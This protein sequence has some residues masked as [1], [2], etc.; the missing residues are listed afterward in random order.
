[1]ETFYW[2]IQYMFVLIS[3]FFVMFVWPS[4]VFRKHLKT[5]TRTYKFAFCI[6]VMIVLINSVCI[7]LGLFNILYQWLFC[8]LFYGT[9]LYSIF[10]GKRISPDTIKRFKY[11]ISGTYGS[12]SMFSDIF[13]FI[14]KKIKGVWK[15]FLKFMEGH[16]FEYVALFVVTIFAYTY[17]SYG[18]LHDYSF[19][20]GDIYVHCM[21]IYNLTSGAIFYSGIY[22]EG[23]HFFIYSE[24]TT[25]GV[26]M[27]S[28]IL[29]TQCI[30]MFSMIICLYIFFREIFKWK[31]SPLVALML[32]FTI[33]AITG[34]Q[35]FTIA[36]MQWI[37]PM[38][39]GYPVTL[40]CCTYL[41]KYLRFSIVEKK[42]KATKKAERKEI[43]LP[44][45]KKTLKIRIPLCFKDENLFIFTMAF[46]GTICIHFYDTIMAF[47][48]CIGIAIALVFKI[49][50]R[51][52]VP[53]IVAVTTG[54][55]IAAA[56]LVVCFA[57]GIPLQGSLYWAMNYFMP[58]DEEAVE[59]TDTVTTDEQGNEQSNEQSSTEAINTTT[60]NTEYSIGGP[61]AAKTVSGIQMLAATGKSL[62]EHVQSFFEMLRDTGY[63]ES[64]HG[65]ERGDFYF[66]FMLISL[67]IGCVATIIRIFYAKLKRIS[68]GHNS[69]FGYILIAVIGIAVHLFVCSK[70]M[71]LPF[72][73]EQYRICALA[74]MVAV[75]TIIVPIDL[76]LGIV[77]K[78]LPKF[79]K[80]LLTIGLIIAVYVVIRV[81]GNY[82][83]TLLYQLTR[84]NST[85]MVT[86]QI[87]NTL[88][89]NSYTIV[90][91]TDE[92]YQIL[93]YGYH[94]ELVH[95]INESEVVSYTLPSEY[96]FI[97]VEKNAL[98]RNQDHFFECP[99]WFSIDDKYY[100]KYSQKHSQ[101]DDLRKETIKEEYAD[102]YF[103]TFREKISAYGTLWQRVILNSKVYVWCQK[104]NAMY[105]NEM[106]VYYED[107]DLLVYYLKQN[108][109]N[110]YEL[111]A[112]DPSV[113][114]PPES[115]AD[116]IW[117]E[118]YKEKMAK[119]KKSTE[120]EK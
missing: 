46:A 75:P 84:Y 17:F 1:M 42:D 90:S 7:L 89:E 40:L 62:I 110:L 79:V 97:F 50:S 15:R 36:R 93:G 41:I 72:L 102:L 101:G 69:Y 82:R 49:F 117:P 67:S 53:L 71:G 70:K 52:L 86:K 111:A 29:F 66:F 27:Y 103:G 118:N 19:G 105:P 12:K 6:V 24:M 108:Q 112:M 31:Y 104:F 57:S 92:L 26:S 61:V 87:V 60:L 5:K 63:K 64:G 98:Y 45:I 59:T 68:L 114:V 119:T 95:F 48:V 16:W 80:S 10:K 33:D 43:K 116:P 34:N 56:P 106:H 78:R 76:I 113:M 38:E 51:K 100:A 8:L 28:A 3:Y 73:M 107:D 58:K 23:M 2:L 120:E 65:K 77:D 35:I 9:F 94:E 21:W 11:L 22:P 91:S 20:C 96:I 54:L 30:N 18:A 99:E 81:T 115:Y 4:V 14:G 39:F 88:P 85:V 109:R 25:T 83:G 74:M 13:S 55:M 37:L 44:F 32:F 47:F